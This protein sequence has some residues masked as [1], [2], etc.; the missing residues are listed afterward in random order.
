MLNY[1]NSYISENFTD[2]DCLNPNLLD[3]LLMASCDGKLTC[4]STNWTTSGANIC[5]EVE[6]HRKTKNDKLTNRLERRAK[7]PGARMLTASSGRSVK[8]S[9][10]SGFGSKNLGGYPRIRIAA[11]P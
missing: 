6:R 11:H 3:T 10:S 5:I 2:G 9:C 8:G 4:E 7:E 1:W